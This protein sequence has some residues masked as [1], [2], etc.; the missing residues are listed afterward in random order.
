MKI[1]DHLARLIRSLYLLPHYRAAMVRLRLFY[2]VRLRRRLRTLSSADAFG[3]TVEHNL[4]YLSQCNP[5]IDLLARPLS[6]LELISPESDVLVVGPR[7]EH[8][9]FTMIGLG[10]GRDRIRG[11]DLISYSPWIDLGDMHA[12]PYGNGSFD[13]IV[14]GWTLSYSAAPAKFAKEMLR[15]ARDGAILAI[16][17][18][19]STM[20][21]ADEIAA[22]GYAI[23]ER[24]RVPRRI[25]SADQIMELFTSSVAEVFFR[26]DAPRKRSHSS[27]GLFSDV[28]N[29]AVIFRI[30]K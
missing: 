9:L 15:I 29:V 10:L 6:V 13:V 24:S 3:V 1:A 28:S 30:R 22:S 21:E 18:E 14:V 8:D 23:Q 17:V 20:T 11:L 2:F 16:A 12:T 19:Y 5:R 7:N 25:N 27:Q 26:H 4:R